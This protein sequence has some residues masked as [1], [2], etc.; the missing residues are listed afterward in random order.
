MI[1]KFKMFE[2][3]D[4]E[5]KIGDYVKLYGDDFDSRLIIFF[6]TH[7]GKIIKIIDDVEENFPYV[8]EFNDI[9]PIGNEDSKICEFEKD[10]IS[11]A[12]PEEAEK[13]L[14]PEE[15]EQYKLEKSTNKYNL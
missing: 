15:Y 10:E 5:P 4:Y 8:V 3:M 12:T 1:T 14:T 6:K 2:N 9:V 11:E 13:Y 7:I